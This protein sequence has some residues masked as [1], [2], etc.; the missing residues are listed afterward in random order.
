MPQGTIKKLIMDKVLV[1]FKENVVSYFSTTPP[2]M[3]A[4]SRS[5]AKA[6]KSNLRKGAG[7]KGLVPRTSR[8]SES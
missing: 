1:S 2:W 7:R 8:S 4:R 3:D 5:C 6:S